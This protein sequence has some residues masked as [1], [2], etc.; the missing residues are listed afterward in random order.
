MISILISL[1]LKTFIKYNKIG[2]GIFKT[3]SYIFVEKCKE[4]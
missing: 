2:Y 4:Y 3:N 1:C